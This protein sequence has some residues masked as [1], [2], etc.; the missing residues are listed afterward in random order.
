MNNEVKNIILRRTHE[1]DRLI[2][3]ETDT[4]VELINLWLESGCSLDYCYKSLKK[5]VVVSFQSQ[6][7]LDYSKR[8]HFNE[9]DSFLTKYI[10][11]KFKEQIIERLQPIKLDG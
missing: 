5:S 6:F 4:M 10:D 2:Q 1:I 8:K 3:L 7:I 9:I 11:E